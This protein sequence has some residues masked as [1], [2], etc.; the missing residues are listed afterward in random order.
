MCPAP[1]LHS[2]QI[3]RPVT[4]S[5]V[6]SSLPTWCLFSLYRQNRLNFGR[7][8]DPLRQ[9]ISS[10]CVKQVKITLNTFPAYDPVTSQ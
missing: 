9:Y 1:F 7:Q 5:T 3:F 4:V 2:M 8:S 6:C 10:A